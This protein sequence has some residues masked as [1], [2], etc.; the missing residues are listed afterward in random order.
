MRRIEGSIWGYNCSRQGYCHLATVRSPSELA[1]CISSSSR[2][3]RE[4]HHARLLLDAR[5]KVVSLG[6]THFLTKRP[7]EDR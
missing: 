1:H 3:S 2:P 4:G 5:E 6:R 7:T